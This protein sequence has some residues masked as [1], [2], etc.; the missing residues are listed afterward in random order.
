[1]VTRSREWLSKQI[2]KLFCRSELKRNKTREVLLANKMAVK[3]YMLGSFMKNWIA[4]DVNCSL[5][6]RVNPHT[7]K[8]RETERS[9]SKRTSQVISAVT[10][11]IE[12]YSASAEESEIEA[13]FFD[14]REIGE[15][16]M[17]M[18]KPLMEQRVSLQDPQ[19][20]SQK[21]RSSKEGSEDRRIPCHGSHLRYFNTR[22]A[23]ER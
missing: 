19:S 10:F 20:A 21:A 15:H 3:L 14:F 17:V 12:R 7:G 23:V 1:M 18:K 13:C 22:N 8:E 4:G 6:V 9:S 5:T 16:P 2:S 11:R